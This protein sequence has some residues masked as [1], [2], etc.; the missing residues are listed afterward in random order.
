MQRR[1]FIKY[2]GFTALAI[3]ASG[4]TSLQQDGQT[5]GNCPTTTD[6]LGPYYRQDAPFRNIIS[7]QENSGQVKLNVV[8]T[9]YGKDCTT[10]LPKVLI[11][12][13]HCD[14]RQKYDMESEDYK[15]RGRFY[16]DENGQYTF[17]TFIPPPYGQRPKHIHYL[18]NKIEGYQELVTQLYFK[19][20][21]RIQ[22]NNWVLYPWDE[23]RILDIYKNE[24]G[25]A[26]VS[27]DLFLSP[28]K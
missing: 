17:Q 21:K 27:L 14:H 8:G 20:D 7:Q 1:Q 12:I 13:W 6:L 15:C 3:S 2:T 28:E 16:T 11:D 9:L 18:V 25:I 5:I 26:E 22:E 10:P 23:N 4:F 19:G 24:E